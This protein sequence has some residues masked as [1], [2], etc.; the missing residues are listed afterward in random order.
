M[1]LT[2]IRKVQGRWAYIIIVYAIIL[3]CQYSIPIS[4]KLVNLAR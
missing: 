3:I 2:S 4:A 1:T